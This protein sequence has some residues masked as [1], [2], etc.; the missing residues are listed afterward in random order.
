MIAIKLG[1]IPIGIDNRFRELSSYFV[2][3]LTD[4]DP[5]FIVSVTEKEIMA[6]IPS[7]RKP[8]EYGEYLAVLRKINMKL[9]DYD[10]FL[11]HAAAIAVDGYGIVFTAKSGVGKSTRVQLWKDAFGDR[12][13][14]INGDK[15]ILRFT[16]NQLTVYGTP[17]TGKEGLGENMSAPV[18]ALCFIER[19]EE[20]SL[21]RIETFDFISRIFNQLIVPREEKQM[22]RLIYLVG[23]I[24]QEI[25]C[26][27]YQCNRDLEKPELL[28]KQIRE[29]TER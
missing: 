26:Y 5:W 23:R 11:F 27:N 17:W 29:E 15:P 6:E 4:E 16:E 1:D 7:F 19:G 21:R 9:I 8:N 14:I 3:Y 12:A 13:K 24:M 20:V 22:D 25:P 28:W 2:S 10:A 18:K